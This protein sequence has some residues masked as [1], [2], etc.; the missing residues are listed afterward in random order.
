MDYN[1]L[2][3]KYNLL[4]DENNRLTKEN[5]R[6]RAQL[7]LPDSEFFQN[8][9]SAKNT[10]PEIFNNESTCRNCVSAVDF[11]SDLP[12]NGLNFAF[13]DGATQILVEH[14]ES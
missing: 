2:R 8:T 7:G 6:L 4:L 10:K 9:A 5:N 11:T 14:I 13:I 12:I 1:E 3:R